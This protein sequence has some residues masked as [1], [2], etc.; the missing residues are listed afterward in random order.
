MAHGSDKPDISRADFTWCMTAIDWGWSVDDTAPRL[1][2]ARGKARENGDRYAMETQRST[3]R[4]PL[5]GVSERR[6]VACEAYKGAFPLA[7][8]AGGDGQG[9]SSTRA[10]RTQNQRGKLA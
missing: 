7:P 8:C 10:L 3:R 9:C 5:Y 1:M 6:N 4:Q 2:E